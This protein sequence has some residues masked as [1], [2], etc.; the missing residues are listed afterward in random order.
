ME[1]DCS[2]CYGYV[3]RGRIGKVV[4]ESFST[5]IPAIER[6]SMKLSGAQTSCKLIGIYNEIIIRKRF[7]YFGRLLVI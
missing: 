4:Q 5:E 7:T 2:D 3:N 1:L 6:E